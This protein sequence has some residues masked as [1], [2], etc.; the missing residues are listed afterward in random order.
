KF[1]IIH[2]NGIAYA[3]TN[4]FSGNRDLI[5]DFYTNDRY[6]LEY[7][8]DVFHSLHTIGIPG[9]IGGSK[10]LSFA[11]EKQNEDSSIVSSEIFEN[12][13]M[14]AQQT[15]V[16]VIIGYSFPIFNNP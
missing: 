10:L 2:L 15:E 6:L 7:L 9:E 11:W 1:G 8:A 12:A 14:I 13:K 3:R 4:S 5:G 16:L